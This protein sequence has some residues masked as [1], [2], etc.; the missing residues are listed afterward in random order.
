MTSLLSET[1]SSQHKVPFPEHIQTPG[2]S[3]YDGN[4]D[5]DDD[6]D[7]DDEDD[8]YQTQGPLPRT[9]SDTWQVLN[10]SDRF[11]KLFIHDNSR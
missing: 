3:D 7:D 8:V 4:N 11:L 2:R 6:N 1:P 9:Y 5:D 10:F